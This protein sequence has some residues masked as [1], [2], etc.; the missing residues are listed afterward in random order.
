MSIEPSVT[1]D[2]NNYIVQTH[3][4]NIEKEGHELIKKLLHTMQV[5]KSLNAVDKARA[6]YA[7][8]SKVDD[9]MLD[10]IKKTKSLEKS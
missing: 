5:Y 10:L 4:E 1:T 2:S 9:K 7:K 3:R 8:Y 6:F